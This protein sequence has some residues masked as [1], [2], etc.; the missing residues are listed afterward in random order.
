MEGWIAGM[1]GIFRVVKIPY[2]YNVGYMSSYI[3]KPIEK[4]YTKNHS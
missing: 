4:Y 2:D 3:V 1:Q